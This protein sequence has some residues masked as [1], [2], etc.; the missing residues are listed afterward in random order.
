MLFEEAMELA[1]TMKGQGAETE[2][3]LARLRASGATIIDS[4]KVTRQIENVNLTEAKRIVDNSAT[5]AD[6]R[7]GNKRIRRM[8]IRALD[9]ESAQ[10]NRPD[11]C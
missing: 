2:A 11:S 5:W 4:L 3:I 1:Q 9:E 6:K 10:Q 7:E 8:L